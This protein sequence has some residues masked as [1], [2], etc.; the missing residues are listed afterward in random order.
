MA[1]MSPRQAF[2]LIGGAG[3]SA[4]TQANTKNSCKHF[5]RFLAV[6]GRIVNDSVDWLNVLNQ[7]ELCKQELLQE[8][9]GYLMT[10]KVPGKNEFYQEGTMLNILGC[11]KEAIKNK[12]P[13]NPLWRLHHSHAGHIFPEAWFSKIRIG[14]TRKFKIR[15]ALLEEELSD[16][17]VY[18]ISHEALRNAITYLHNRECYLD[19]EKAAVMAFTFNCDGRA[20][21]CS[22]VSLK[23]TEFNPI[24]GCPFT[25]WNEEKTGKRYWLPI[26]PSFEHW[27]LDVLFVLFCY[28]ILGGGG[29]YTSELEYIVAME[30]RQE[31]TVQHE[32]SQLLFPGLM[33]LGGDKLTR[34]TKDLQIAG[35]EGFPRSKKCVAKSY[36]CGQSQYLFNHRDGGAEVADERGGWNKAEHSGPSRY[37]YVQGCLDMM[38]RAAKI[39]SGWPYAYEPVHSPRIKDLVTVEERSKIASM[40]TELFTLPH[41]GSNAI[42]GTD[43][44]EL[45]WQMFASFLRFM[46]QYIVDLNKGAGCLVMKRVLRIARA[47]RIALAD[48]QKWSEVVAVDFKTRN[49]I[50]LRSPYPGND[51]NPS[52][53]TLT[54]S[55]IQLK[56]EVQSMKR[57]MVEVRRAVSDLV[58]SVQVIS[59]MVVMQSPEESSTASGSVKRGRRDIDDSNQSDERFHPP[60][61]SVAMAAEAFSQERNGNGDETS[62]PQAV[63]QLR[64]VNTALGNIANAFVVDKHNGPLK[65]VVESLIDSR[66]AYSIQISSSKR[67]SEAKAS[68]EY[69]L[70]CFTEEEKDI[71]RQ[72]LPMGGEGLTNGK[73]RQQI[74]D[75][76]S[77]L[78]LTVLARIRA[79]LNL[80]KACKKLSSVWEK[81]KQKN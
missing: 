25:L 58:K 15:S 7:Q 60:S 33:F 16:G 46:P 71:A 72:E 5:A 9:V 38:T 37:Y 50:A 76:K 24:Y 34:W 78:Q 80:S 44:A 43:H 19:I 56:D 21:E 59:S 35:V 74:V 39:S 77:E 64:S 66:L 26:F 63:P 49:I 81:I 29:H 68:M 73:S 4:S 36:R 23:T 10:S 13:E 40:L 67:R 27:Q 14:L 31:D 48:L 2:E 32:L 79:R 55:I 61:D 1:A 3:N 45:G 8:F 6:T 75:E 12:F 53:V 54:E 30:E 17:H 51:V 11:V 18:P 65:E 41:L 42:M 28:L 57:E 22:F 47:H 69:I 62:L 20:N 70:T 52:L